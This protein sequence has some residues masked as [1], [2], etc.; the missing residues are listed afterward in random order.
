MS[1][2]IPNFPPAA[3][4]SAAYIG[5]VLRHVLLEPLNLK[6][7]ILYKLLCLGILSD[8]KNHKITRPSAP[9]RS[10][11]PISSSKRYHG[12][13]LVSMLRFLTLL[14]STI[15]VVFLEAFATSPDILPDR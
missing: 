10:A 3:G 7:R 11:E 15:Q 13:R 6:D 14:D 9:R 1:W 8:A 5:I 12:R 4:S 2:E